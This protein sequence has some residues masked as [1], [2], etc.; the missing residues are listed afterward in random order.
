MKSKRKMN[1]KELAEYKEFREARKSARIK[2]VKKE[3]ETRKR[4]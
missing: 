2:V 1:E 3:T 4:K